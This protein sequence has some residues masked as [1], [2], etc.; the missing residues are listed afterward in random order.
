MNNI[1]ANINKFRQFT[2]KKCGVGVYDNTGS[3]AD[4]C[5][6]CGGW[7]KSGW[8]KVLSMS[9]LGVT[10]PDL[11]VKNFNTLARRLIFAQFM[12]FYLEVISILLLEI[13]YLLR[14]FIVCKKGSIITDRDKTTLGGYITLAE[15][16]GLEPILVTRLR[17]F[18]D[19]RI[20]AEHKLLMGAI[21][22]KE[23][24]PIILK[25]KNLIK[26]LYRTVLANR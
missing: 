10:N 21:S 26:D 7:P 25:D 20:R 19:L 5:S 4:L 23:L 6:T 13:D 3:Y 15:H 9:S 2:C 8:K 17:N 1:E 12:G 11:S 22:Y 18:N 14:E 24:K 16:E